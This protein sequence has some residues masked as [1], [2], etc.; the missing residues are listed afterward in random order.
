MAAMRDVT[1]ILD[2]IQRGD[3]QA[4]AQLL[5]LVYDDLRRRAAALMAH[6]DA[7]QTL[8]AT[9]LVHE[10]FLQ[11]VGENRFA[12]RSHFFRVAAEAM[13]RI[14]VDR[15]RRK[16]R[17][18]HGG[19]HRRIAFSDVEPADAIPSEDLLALDEALERFAAIDPLKAELVKLRYFA[20]LSEAE[21]AEALGISRPTAS[22]HWAYARAWLIAAIDGRAT[23]SET[24]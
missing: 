7:G 21:A 9:A 3:P 6:E 5:P 15:A 23:N 12:D 14:L 1:E 17:L 16:G 4:A 24:P 2:R 20:G 13:R 10:A 8:D 22:R 18:R 11:L 19:D